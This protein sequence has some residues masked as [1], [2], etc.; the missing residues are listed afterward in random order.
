MK[1]L[2]FFLIIILISSCNLGNVEFYRNPNSDI[3]IYIVKEGQLEINDTDFNINSLQLEKTPWVKY[4]D[5]DFYDW[6]AHSFYLNREVDRG[7][8]SG[9]HFVVTSGQKR[10]FAGVFFPMFMSS[11]PALPS[12]TPDDGFFSP[13]DVVRF[14]RFGF[15]RPGKL[16]ENL[17][18]K[19]ELI[20]AGILREGIN[21]RITGLKKENQTTLKYTFK[22]SNLD[23]ENIY[24]LDPDKMGDSRFHYY[25]N[26]DSLQKEDKYYWAEDF[27]TAASDKIKSSWY[28]KLSPGRSI[29]R[30]VTLNGFKNLPVGEVT[31][32]FSFPGA[33]VKTPG[34]WKKS[35][36]RIWLG[37]FRV[38][39]KL[40]LR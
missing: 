16:D 21:V 9:R 25:T 2:F 8:Y 19:S 23:A 38:E 34:G 7:K 3:N 10:L 6:S 22:V 36:G 12:I 26:G 18:F 11:L 4:S 30:I 28:Y 40:S 14:G 29:T 15:V 37:D 5:I 17:G 24:I 20:S 32:S 39:Q 33:P 1:N 27:N 35:D 13:K 31:A